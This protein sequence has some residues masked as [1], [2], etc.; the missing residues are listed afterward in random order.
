MAKA[1]YL[2]CANGIITIGDRVQT[3]WTRDEGGDDN[4]YLGKVVDVSNDEGHV[5][6]VYDDGDRWTGKADEVYYVSPQEMRNRTTGVGRFMLLIKKSAF[7]C[8]LMLIMLII[9]IPMMLPRPVRGELPFWFSLPICAG[10]EASSDGQA[11][12]RFRMHIPGTDEATSSTG[13]CTNTCRVHTRDGDCDDGGLG[14]SYTFCALGTDCADCGYRQTALPGYACPTG[15][16][17][18]SPPAQISLDRLDG[19]QAGFAYAPTI[20][21]SSGSTA[22]I[23]LVITDASGETLLPEL[24][25]RLG[26]PERGGI[27]SVA[28]ADEADSMSDADQRRTRAL[29]E[30]ARSSEGTEGSAPLYRGPER[31]LL[32]GGSSTGS[33]SSALGGRSRTYGTARWGRSG[34]GRYTTRTYVPRFHG[35]S[36]HS[37]ALQRQAYFYGARAVTM[38]AMLAAVGAHHYAYR[39]PSRPAPGVCV[40]SRLECGQASYF[41]AETDL[42]RY[43]LAQATFVAP[44]EHL[45][46]PL[47]VTVTTAEVYFNSASAYQHGKSGPSLMLSFTTDDGDEALERRESLEFWFT[48]L[49]L[50][51]FCCPLPF[52]WLLSPIFRGCDRCLAPLCDS[53]RLVD[54]IPLLRRAMRKRD[55]TTGRGEGGGKSLV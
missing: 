13:L 39:H 42:D 44:K 6:I 5:G 21:L 52:T 48:M 40:G 12:S 18:P 53:K 26:P 4:W 11:R 46:W 47:T 25:L 24:M 37:A 23:T 29:R 31:R 41:K 19:F 20:L 8:M 17:T 28:A 50:F 14:S 10:A 30:G 55:A 22:L 45:R 38:G 49:L 51:Y 16:I 34:G 27:P 33:F 7:F 32:K 9:T 2:P 1:Q 54:S 36:A 3:Q 15:A 43:E 35:H